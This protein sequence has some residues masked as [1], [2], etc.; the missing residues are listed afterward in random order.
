[1]R[2]Q[3]EIRTTETLTENKAEEKLRISS[4][5]KENATSIIV[6]AGI[7][8]SIY[9]TIVLPIKQLEFGYNDTVN[10]H[11]KTVQDE[12]VRLSNEIKIQ[13]ESIQSLAASTVRLE[14]LMGQ[15]LD[16]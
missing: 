15:I 14:T 5:L 16:K 4:A 1:M 12:Q 3:T 9:Q 2:K 13:G 6:I 7:M 10:N 8:F 11:L